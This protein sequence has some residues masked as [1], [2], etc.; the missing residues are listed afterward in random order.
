M[1]DGYVTSGDGVRLYYRR[2]GEGT[3]V[4]LIPDTAFLFD[5]F[6]RLASGRT[7]IF[8]DVRN[9]GR[10]DAVA[11]RS[12]LERGVHH[13]VEDLE[14][15]RRH[16]DLDSV[17]LIGHSY[18]G[19]MIALYAM[20]YQT[21]ARMVQIG[22]AQAD[23]GKTYPPELM[24]VD[25]VAKEVMAGFAKL[26]S[27]APSSTPAQMHDRTMALLRML[28][29][30]DPADVGKLKWD[31]SGLPTEAAGMQHVMM[32]IMPSLRALRL[33]SD[34]IGK[35]SAPTLVIHGRKDR[36]APY[37]GG[38]D[39]AAALPN[40]RLLTLDD[41]AHAPWVEAPERLFESIDGFFRGEWPAAAERVDLNA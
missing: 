3:N 32:N 40:A 1:N 21:V 34:D 8:Y 36:Q 39:W 14:A 25:A 28:L 23:A 19:L 22:P 27:E 16:F 13:D 12:K 37:G 31:V 5:D 29:V 20:K 17:N 11:D 24:N 38:R 6:R 9:R 4:V 26:R 7:V 41:A 35:V 18:L 2:A 33:T 15:V 30:V 10:S